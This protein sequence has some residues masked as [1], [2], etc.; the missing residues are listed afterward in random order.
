MVTNKYKNIILLSQWD[1]VA[2]TQ[3]GEDGE[4]TTLV[5]GSQPKLKLHQEEMAWE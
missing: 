2:C 4:I 1:N 3:E 5:L